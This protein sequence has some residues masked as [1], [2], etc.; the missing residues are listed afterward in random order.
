MVL[1]IAEVRRITIT[2]CDG[3]AKGHPS[4][5]SETLTPPPRLPRRALGVLADKSAGNPQYGNRSDNQF[6]KP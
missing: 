6:A 3:H 5:D 4:E 2:F 1:L